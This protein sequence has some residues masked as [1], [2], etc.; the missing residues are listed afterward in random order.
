MQSCFMYPLEGHSETS[1]VQALLNPFYH[2]IKIKAYMR[3]GGWG[4]GTLCPGV[5]CP[6]LPQVNSDCIHKEEICKVVSGI[7][8]KGIQK[9]Q[10]TR[11]FS[12]PFNIT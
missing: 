7:L 9:L 1:T 10:L 12:I 8:L 5:E 6:P 4:A 3:V 11:L 2:Y